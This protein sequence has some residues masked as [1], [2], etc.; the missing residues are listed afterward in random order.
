MIA[1]DIHA[2]REIPPRPFGY[3]INQGILNRVLMV[4]SQLF[5]QLIFALSGFYF[6]QNFL[7]SPLQRRC[8]FI[9]N[10]YYYLLRIKMECNLHVMDI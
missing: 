10:R 7:S 9:R 4:I 1:S 3:G 5:N 8:Y 2:V 6:T